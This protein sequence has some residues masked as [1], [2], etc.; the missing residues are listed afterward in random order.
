MKAAVYLHKTKQNAVRRGHPWIFPKAITKTSGKLVTGAL[1]DIFDAEGTLLG[2]GVFN[3]HS[4][5]RV[6]VLA[7]QHE[8]MVSKPLS[9]I[10][11]HRLN[12]ALRIRQ[13]LN[14]PNESTTAYRL[15]N[16]EADGL[17]GLTID[18]FNQFSVVASSAYWV[19]A[20]KTMIQ[21]AV[22]DLLPHEEIIWLPQV[23]PLAQDGWKKEAEPVA[24]RNAQV[25]EAGIIYQVDFSQA[26]KTGLFLDQRENHQ[27]IAALAKGKRVLDLYSYTGG[28]A[29]HAAKAGASKITAVDSSAHAIAQAKENAQLNQLKNIEFIEADARDYL[30]QAGDYDLVILDPPKLVPSQQHLERAKNYYRFLHR[31][32]FKAME[33][34]S[35][36]MTCNCS[37]ALSA[38]EFCLLVSSQAAAAGKQARLLGTFGPA[39]CHPTLATFPEGNYLTAVL[40]AVV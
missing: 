4:L 40:L 37:S 23:K 35:L 21:Q 24:A 11:A 17:S 8:T 15:F 26:Q 32:V 22:Q 5:Y 39:S 33:P 28:F 3:E 16:S 38:Q 19:E 1:V 34:G 20:N 36:L 27:R 6:R 31:E 13:A 9:T 12:Q 2:V 29:L 7:L 14:L 18:R 30:T 10:V 25:C